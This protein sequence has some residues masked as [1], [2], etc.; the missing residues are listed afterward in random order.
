MT[1]GCHTVHGN[2]SR[3]KVGKLIGSLSLEIKVSSP[4]VLKKAETR[5][6]VL[7]LV[8]TQKKMLLVVRSKM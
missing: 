5:A 7:S 2:F 3:H 4:S 8:Q 1:F 6:L